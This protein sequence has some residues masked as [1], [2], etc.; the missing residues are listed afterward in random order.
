MF[1]GSGA[2]DAGVCVPPPRGHGAAGGNSGGDEGA[3]VYN[4]YVLNKG[5]RGS[6]IRLVLSRSLLFVN[7]KNSV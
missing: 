4:I 3:V 6:T 5:L 7:M 1:D 2:D